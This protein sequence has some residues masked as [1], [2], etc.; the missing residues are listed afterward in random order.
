MRRALDFEVEDQRK[1]RRQKKTWKKQVED[2]SM[3]IG[4]CREDA[5]Q[6]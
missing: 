2:K 3:Y 1:K 6:R 4:L 5:L